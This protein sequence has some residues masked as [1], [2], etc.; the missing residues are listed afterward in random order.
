VAADSE[1]SMV[2]ALLGSLRDHT[3]FPTVDELNARVE[4]LADRHPKCVQLDVVGESRLGEP[5]TMASVGSGEEHVLLIGGPH[6]NE[7]VGF[8]TGLEIAEHLAETGVPWGRT[9]HLI[10]C[11]DPDA[12][13]LNERWYSAPSSIATHHRHFYRPAMA[14]QPE[15]DF[16][17][18][19]GSPPS[20]G[21]LPETLALMRVIDALRPRLQVPLHNA[22][23]GGAFFTVNRSVPGIAEP[24]LAAV[25]RHGLPLE[26]H[27]TDA[28][29][30]ERAGEGVYV[31]PPT[32]S[33]LPPVV[34][35]DEPPHR[36]TYLADYAAHHGTLTFNAEVPMWRVRDQVGGPLRKGE[37]LL[38]SAGELEAAMRPWEDSWGRVES[39]L[40]VQSPFRAALLYSFAASRSI[41]AMW[42]E[43]AHA[44]DGDRLAEPG[45]LVGARHSVYRFS[46]RC[47][48]MLLRQLDAEL[49]AGNH[50]PAVR[51]EARAL[52][53]RF[54]ELCET[55]QLAT[56]A[57]ALPIGTLVAL[58]AEAIMRVAD[59]CLPE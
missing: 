52:D 27:P 37:F 3:R 6:P 5:I 15:W 51:A 56:G 47:S 58:Q 20:A 14:A 44:D 54:T 57:Q 33:A 48:G 8:L 13:R 38:R 19:P 43:Q 25:A 26:T 10:P 22:D 1:S 16:S 4:L 46:L 41:A 12:A 45:E 11:I 36:G 23:F 7:P 59:L 50:T 34:E 29:G 24:L 17:P 35:G 28:N 55:V 42:R 32:D 2:G 18:S 9:W 31:M 40:A 21:Q 53:I 49:A 30:W 39:D